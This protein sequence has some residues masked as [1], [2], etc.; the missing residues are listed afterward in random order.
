VLLVL[1]ALLALLVRRLR[2]SFSS[3]GSSKRVADSPRLPLRES[4]LRSRM[5][6]SANESIIHD[7]S[8][9]DTDGDGAGLASSVPGSVS[10]PDDR[11]RLNLDLDLKGPSPT[12]TRR[13]WPT[14]TRPADVDVVGA[15]KTTTLSDRYDPHCRIP[16][17][18][19]TILHR[20]EHS[21]RAHAE[22]RSN[23]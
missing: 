21:T 15:D 22:Q 16:P 13:R 17:R 9:D 2:F 14:P 10:P 23:L 4:R 1:L 7:S 11:T 12:P 18:T 8:H 6:S 5:S 19:A 20:D 3:K